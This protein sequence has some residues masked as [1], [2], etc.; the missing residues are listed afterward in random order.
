MKA[1]TGQIPIR[2]TESGR[3]TILMDKHTALNAKV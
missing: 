2:P 1:R 3:V